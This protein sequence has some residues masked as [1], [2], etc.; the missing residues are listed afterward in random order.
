MISLK[1]I[2][3]LISLISANAVNN[4]NGFILETIYLASSLHIYNYFSLSPA[5]PKCCCCHFVIMRIALNNNHCRHKY[6]YYK[7][8]N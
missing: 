6:V 4:I 7:F 8:H 2:D 5:K 1:M 3:I